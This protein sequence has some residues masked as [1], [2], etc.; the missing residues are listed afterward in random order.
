VAAVAEGKIL[1]RITAESR[2]FWEA[3]REKRFITTRCGQCAA[4]SFPPR[5]LCPACGSDQREWIELSGRGEIY[6][7]TQ[8]RIVARGYIPEAPY[9]TAMVDLA[10]GPRILTRIENAAYEE[11]SIGQAVRIGFKPLTE[12]ITFFFFEPMERTR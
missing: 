5:R 11:L 8:N 7:F 9:L 1:P 3:L 10:E 4:V 2:P 6:A 12:E